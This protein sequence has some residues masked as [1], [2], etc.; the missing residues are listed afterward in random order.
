MATTERDQQISETMLEHAQE[1]FDSGDLIQASE[2]AWG[3]VAHCLKA[4]AGKRGWPNR[5]HANLRN[6]ASWLMDRSS[7]PDLNRTKFMAIERLHNN[8][9]E[10]VLEARD[11]RIGIAHAKSLI[12]VLNDVDSRMAS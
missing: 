3:A 11:V 5:S 2:K 8:F 7:D 1:Q 10:E 6:N 12:E 9:Y 4:I